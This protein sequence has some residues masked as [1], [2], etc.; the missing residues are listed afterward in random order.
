[1][2]TEVSTKELTLEPGQSPATFEVLVINTSDRFASFQL[3]MFAAGVESTQTL[4]VK[5]NNPFDWY[6]VTPDIS[7]KKPPGDQTQFQVTVVRSPIPGFIGLVNL[8]V[9]VFSL[10]LGSEDRHILRLHVTKSGSESPFKLDLPHNPIQTFPNTEVEIPVRLY[11]TSPK[12][13]AVALSCLSP[14]RD[15]FMLETQTLTLA[16]NQWTDTALRCR[17]P[18]FTAAQDYPFTLKVTSSNETPAQIQGTIEV[19]PIGIVQFGARPKSHCLPQ[20]RPWI[21]QWW[22]PPAVYELEF[23]NQSNLPQQAKAEILKYRRQEDRQLRQLSILPEQVNLERGETQ[24][25]ELIANAQRPWLGPG[26]TERI[27]VSGQSM[28]LGADQEL[29][30]WDETKNQENPHIYL[31]DPVQS[32]ELKLLPV[33][34][35]WLQLLLAFL[36]LGLLWWLW[37]F[38]VRLNYHTGP[39]N[40]VEF[41]GLG[42]RVISASNDQ[43]LRGWRVKEKRIHPMGLLGDLGKAGRTNRY[44]PVNNNRV[45]VGLENGEI[46]IWDL[47]SRSKQPARS[48]SYRRDDRVMDLVFTKD[49]QFLF[50]AHGSGLLLQW[51]IGPTAE[52][53][54]ASQPQR[55]QEFDFAIYDLAFVSPEQKT[56]AIAGRYNQLVLWNWERDRLQAVPYRTGGQDEYI[57]SLATAEEKPFFLA[58]AD[59]RGYISLWNLRD[60][61]QNEGLPCQILE[62]W[63]THQNQPI[64]SLA[65]T[66]DGC[67]LA[68][69]GDNG[70]VMLWSLQRSGERSTQNLSGQEIIRLRSAL[71]SLD[72]IA[73][74]SDLV[75]VTGGDDYQVRLHRVKRPS[76][77]CS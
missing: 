66:D 77:S 11:N 69:T 30:V 5:E 63:Q 3:Q 41:N 62:R 46:Q 52:L 24:T 68:S 61:V 1:M 14:Q 57:T 19:L 50:S 65:L 74:K 55:L 10:E 58:T 22:T 25:L 15:W 36:I 9:K 6:T 73:I 16:S 27:E 4:G 64:R 38:Q 18:E 47:L 26:R 59:D 76:S 32:L 67:Y 8:T 21:P 12:V 53:V 31:K 17:V 71:N 29:S 70:Q 75:I 35:R 72:L 13:I 48:L 45:A 34:P 37:Y 28:P 42:N 20:S 2:N 33:I 49:S 40:S 56:I 43:T 51:S 54:N 39:I 60:C 44:R 23:T 7:T